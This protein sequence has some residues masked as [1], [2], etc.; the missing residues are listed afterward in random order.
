MQDQADAVGVAHQR[1]RRAE[2]AARDVARDDAALL[3]ADPVGVGG[4]LGQALRRHHLVVREAPAEIGRTSRGV[5][6]LHERERRLPVEPLE[7]AD[8]ERLD[9]HLRAPPVEAVAAQ[10]VEQ[11]LVEAQ[12]ERLEER[13]VLGLGVDADAVLLG[14]VDDLLEGRDLE[15]PVQRGVGG[16]DLGQAL[17]RPEGLELGEGEVEREP[18]V[19]E[20][21]V[22]DRHGPAP[23]RELGMIGDVGRA[24]DVG[25]MAGDE[26]A[27]PCEHEV[28]LDVVGAHLDRQR[29]R[30]DRVLGP[31]RRRATVADDQRQ[32]APLATA[33]M[34]RRGGGGHAERGDGRPRTREHRST[35]QLLHGSPSAD[36]RPSKLADPSA[37]RSATTTSCR[38]RTCTREGGRRQITSPGA[39][40]RETPSWRA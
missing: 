10:R 13:R 25:L 35:G 4:D 37:S 38:G 23:A 12:A 7:V 18:G 27:V 26:L 33:A 39:E 28:G 32:S 21:D 24:A 2:R 6:Q 29:V 20:D 19:R 1:R 17:L 3:R 16:P 9:E 34:P 14:E 5:D 40:I 31:V 8:L 36:R 15:E 11:R 22:V 30:A